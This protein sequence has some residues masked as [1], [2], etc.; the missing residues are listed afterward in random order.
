VVE[1]VVTA[2]MPESIRTLLEL[3]DDTTLVAR[4]HRRLI[5]RH[6]PDA[7]VGELPPEHR[8]VLLVEG[9][10][11]AV[12]NGGF[13][14]LVGCPPP[15]DPDY[16]HT[17]AAYAA[18][19]D[20]PAVAA[21]RRAFDVFPDRVPPADREERFLLFARG[22][23]AVDGRL[24]TDFFEAY[25]GLV[26][27]LAAYIRRHRGAFADLDSRRSQTRQRARWEVDPAGAGSGRLPR[28][29]RVAFYA[30]CA[31]HV[32]PLW[33]EAWPD[34]PPGH[35]EAVDNAIRLAELSAAGGAPVGDLKTAHLEAVCA[36]GAALVTQL[37]VKREDGV[38]DPPARDP[39]LASLVA[40]AAAHATEF[41]HS[42]TAQG[43]YGYAKGAVAIVGREDLMDRM[44]EDFRRLRRA[45]RVGGWTDRTSVP[46]DAFDPDYEPPRKPWW[47]LW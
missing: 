28:W 9:T 25:D 15:G 16:Q 31:R 37:G 35:A 23:A 34:A 39:E 22:N 17:L 29:A 40:N 10:A 45:V 38:V 18:L 11:A 13:T 47:K 1:G 30:R 43:S 26:A 36:A 2:A 21:V 5:D 46:P 12:M 19:G 8:T 3:T 32:R 24:N 42:P 7:D 14:A 27:E 4:L 33:D 41:L 44:Q 20:G 6:G